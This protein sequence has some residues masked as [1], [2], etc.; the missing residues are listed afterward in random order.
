MFV[1]MLFGFLVINNCELVLEICGLMFQIECEIVYQLFWTYHYLVVFLNFVMQSVCE[2]VY[3]S[4]NCLHAKCNLI[5][6]QNQF[7]LVVLCRLHVNMKNIMLHCCIAYIAWLVINE[8]ASLQHVCFCCFRCEV[9]SM[10]IQQLINQLFT[11]YLKTCSSQPSCSWLLMLLYLTDFKPSATHVLSSYWQVFC[12]NKSI[13][14]WTGLW[15]CLQN[16]W[17]IWWHSNSCSPHLLCFSCNACCV[18]IWKFRLAVT[19]GTVLL[20]CWLTDEL[21]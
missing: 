3:M 19:P 21:H 18:S 1:F 10:S 12:L 9:E 15:V 7:H 5:L 11:T 4:I 16:A 8:D 6:Q 2:H 14:H 13:R 20:S 17:F